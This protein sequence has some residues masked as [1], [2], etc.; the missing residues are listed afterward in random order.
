MKRTVF[1]ALAL[2]MLVAPSAFAQKT[3]K[4]TFTSV[5]VPATPTP[6]P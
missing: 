5:S 4:L 1:F 2:L 3:V 6:R